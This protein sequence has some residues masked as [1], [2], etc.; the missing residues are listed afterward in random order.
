MIAI[1]QLQEGQ[2][3]YKMCRD[4]ETREWFVGTAI[5]DRIWKT[6][7]RGNFRAEIIA[8]DFTSNG[9]DHWTARSVGPD[10]FLTPLAAVEHAIWN[11]LNPDPFN[12]GRRFVEF[13]LSL[14]K[15]VEA[16]ERLFALWRSLKEASK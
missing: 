5:V 2:R 6:P 15:E 12:A 14:E 1:F 16:T 8:E 7:K 11:I 10:W 4:H 13:F 9:K 3:I